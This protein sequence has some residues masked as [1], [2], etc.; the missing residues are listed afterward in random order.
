MDNGYL[1]IVKR[2]F[3]SLATTI[4]VKGQVDAV[5]EGNFAWRSTCCNYPVKQS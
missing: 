2:Y 1:F 4:N 3:K 5:C